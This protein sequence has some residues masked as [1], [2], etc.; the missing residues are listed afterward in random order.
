[1]HVHRLVA[2]ADIQAR[3][4]QLLDDVGL[5]RETQAAYAAELSGGQRQRVV[6]ARAL[7]MHPRFIVLDEVVSALDVS[8]QGQIINLLL[9]LQREHGLTYLFI[10]HNL[11][12][13]RHIA[14]E[15]AV[16]YRGRIV[17]M[18]P[19]QRLFTTPRHPYTIALLAAMLQPDPTTARQRVRETPRPI[20]PE[21]SD[22]LGCKYRNT[23][24]FA[25]EICAAQYPPLRAVE[26]DHRVACH[27]DMHCVMPQPTAAVETELT[28]SHLGS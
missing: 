15:I 18:A 5:P 23:C 19:T 22:P 10:S 6:I 13:V 8:I 28:V 1:L 20:S 9:D 2:P 21:P 12:I 26:A 4:A 7:A 25:R 24:A 11:G 16:M 14:H 27:V 17:E 3:V